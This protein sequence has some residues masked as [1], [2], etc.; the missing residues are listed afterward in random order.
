MKMEPI[1]LSGRTKNNSD[2]MGKVCVLP[3]GQKGKKGKK[4][5]KTQA[6]GRAGRF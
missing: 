3:L 5:A 2:V 6:K 4:G 1:R